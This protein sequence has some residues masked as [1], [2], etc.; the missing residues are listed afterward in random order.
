MENKEKKQWLLGALFLSLAVTSFFGWY[1]I[2][3]VI[4]ALQVNSSWLVAITWF[5]LSVSI[6]C[7]IA[8]SFKQKML[9]IAAALLLFVPGLFFIQDW[10]FLLFVCGGVLLCMMGLLRMRHAMTLHVTIHI[11]RSMQHGTSWIVLSL[12]LVIAS[13][14]YMQIRDDSGD[15]LLQMLSLDQ[16]SHVLLNR[17]LGMV[18]PEFKKANQENMTVDEFLM[19]FQ[20]NQA[21]GEVAMTTPPDEELLQMAGLTPSDPR[22]PQ[23]LTQIKSGI[24]KN[25]KAISPQKIILE[26]SRKQLSDTVG[27]PLS[28]QE[29]IADVLSQIIDQRIRTYFKP[30][31]A[32]NSTSILPFILSIILFVTLWSLGALLMILWRFMTAGLFALLCR[33][34]VIEVQKVMIEQEVIA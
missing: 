16:T 22:S 5:S 26:Q 13:F 21:L 14:Y 18:N 25:T 20:K 34:G 30:S 1:A 23:A 15:E 32:N 6:V 4:D 10:I 33:L 19:T 17:A 3:Q 27:A 7:L 2:G 11:R 12:A 31:E 9:S 28:G 29:H 24:E 8:L